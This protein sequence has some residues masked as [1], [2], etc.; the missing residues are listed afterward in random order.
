MPPFVFQKCHSG[1]TTNFGWKHTNVTE[2]VAK[3]FIEFYSCQGLLLTIFVWL[4]PSQ[5]SYARII[6]SSE[7]INKLSWEPGVH[8][9]A[10]GGTIHARHTERFHP[11]L[12]TCGQW[13]HDHCAG[14]WKEIV[15]IVLIFVG[16]LQQNTLTKFKEAR[17]HCKYKTF[18]KD[19]YQHLERGLSPW[20]HQQ[21]QMCQL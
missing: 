21:L 15:T 17:Y 2:E 8:S 9:I 7:C 5:E 1:Q 19:H 12:L 14:L 3:K 18:L 11:D 20:C 6:F 13:Q 4:N 16:C 10:A